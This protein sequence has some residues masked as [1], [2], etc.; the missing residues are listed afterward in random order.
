MVEYLIL[1]VL[2]EH[3]LV[4][5]EGEMNRKVA[6]H[7]PLFEEGICLRSLNV[8]NTSHMLFYRNVPAQ[9]WFLKLSSMS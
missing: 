4:V 3:N 2:L 7:G 8:L 5:S 1:F 6:N 9:I